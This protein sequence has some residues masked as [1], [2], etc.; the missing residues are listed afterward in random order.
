MKK[1]LLTIGL[2]ALNLSLGAQVVCHVDNGGILF[3]GENALVYNGGGVQTKGNG[4]YDI[5]GNVMI[6]GDGSAVLKTLNTTG[7]NKTDGGNFI[8]RL[9]SPASSATSTYGQ[10]Y[11]NGLSQSNMSAIVD[12]EYRT[13]AHGSYQQIALPFNNKLISS[14]S[15]S[16]SAI[17]TL[18][19][20][21]TNTRYS[22][23]EILTWNN[24]T[25][26]SDNLPVTSVT[27]GNTTYYMLGSD[28]F[29]SDAPPASMPSNPDPSA[30]DF[31]TNPTRAGVV[32]TLKG[33]PFANVISETLSNAADGVIFGT[34]GTNVN[35]YNE[36]YNTYLGDDWEA[37][38]PWTGNYGK[39]IYQFGNPYLTNLDLGFINTIEAGGTTDN[40]N[41][42]SIRGIRYDPGAV[43]YS[44]TVGTT[45]VGAKYV[46]FT[47]ADGTPD[48]SYPVGD[49]GL[50]IKPMQTFVVKLRNN[51]TAQTLNFDNLRRFKNSR[52]LAGTDYDVT[53]LKSTTLSGN[54]V[55]QLGVIGL[56]ENGQELARTYY[57]VYSTATTGHTSGETVQT[58]LGSSNIIGTYEESVNGGLDTNYS[59]SYWLYINEAN[60]IDFF[61]KAIP[62]AL[63]SDAIKSLKFE[64]RENAEL[65]ADGA[66][67]LSTGI[68]FYYK[69]ANGEISEIAQSQ[70]IPVVGDEY[71]LFYG[72]SDIVLGTGGTLKPSRTKVIYNGAID[73]FV[74]RFDSEWKKADIQV[75]D[76]SGKLV[77]SQKDVVADKD[78][79]INLA[80]ANASYIV[81][82]VSEKGEKVSSKIIR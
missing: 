32:Y 30:L 17:G 45:S 71:S 33:E 26:V 50:I 24:L 51:T 22:K 65:I 57:A 46:N 3:V 5:R 23:N 8:L 58:T 55:K 54:T 40:N 16:S 28:G 21:F 64:I 52:R 43:L 12:K 39:N 61:G 68:G 79:E 44:P 67:N 2:L 34:G 80:K 75:Y 78:F 69:T 27:P 36:R 82:A 77:I 6:E 20:T 9:N 76:M 38:T 59:G 4:I 49:I 73:K 81:T 19:K 14:L 41:I 72:K 7:G 37:A 63:Y 47:L 62:L 66:H 25:A 15:G 35:S 31:A 60:E 1:N 29:N 48:S 18:G 11:I 10:L 13:P 42:T 53:A 74:V 56:D 70:V